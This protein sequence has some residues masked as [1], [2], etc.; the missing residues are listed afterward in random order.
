MVFGGDIRAESPHTP[1]ILG[2]SSAYRT[3]YSITV[4]DS[5]SIKDKHTSGNGVQIASVTQTNT[6]RSTTAR[7]VPPKDAA[8][9]SAPQFN[10]DKFEQTLD[11]WQKRVQAFWKTASPRVNEF[12]NWSLTRLGIKHDGSVP[13]LPGNYNQSRTVKP[14]VLK[15]VNEAHPT[16]LLRDGRLK[17]VTAH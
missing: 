16:W 13:G 14:L 9:A 10:P 6:N 8:K 15:S 3:D 7:T 4:R 17:T 11:D 12:Y 5:G 2:V 1:P